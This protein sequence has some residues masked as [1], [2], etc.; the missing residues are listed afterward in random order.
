[1]GLPVAR[2]L[3]TGGWMSDPGFR[4]LQ[5]PVISGILKTHFGLV[6]KDERGAAG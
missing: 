1:M 4:I 6:L 3:F 2:R 5:K